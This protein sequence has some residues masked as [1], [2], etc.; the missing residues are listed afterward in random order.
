[1]VPGEQLQAGFRVVTKDP[2]HDAGSVASSFVKLV[3]TGHVAPT[4]ML[5]PGPV[6]GHFD[7]A[8]HPR[9]LLLRIP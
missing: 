5:M 7:E 6:D 8:V 9:L 2:P 3:Q 1:M 4:R